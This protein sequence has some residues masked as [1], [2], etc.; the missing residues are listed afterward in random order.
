MNSPKTVISPKF[1]LDFRCIAADCEDTCC[2]GW[3][4]H[5]DK[6]HYEK[7]EKTFSNNRE[8]TD[9]FHK[10]VIKNEDW[11][12]QT[13]DFA[14]INF[15]EN[16]NCPFLDDRKLCSI[17][18]TFGESVI[19]NFCAMYPKDIRRVDD[20]LEVSAAL[21]CPEVARKVIL[22]KGSMSLNYADNSIIPRKIISKSIFSSFAKTYE[23]HIDDVR[24]I[25]FTILDNEYFP[26]HS[27]TFFTIWFAEQTVPM[28]HEGCKNIP[29]LY[30]SSLLSQFT[31]KDQLQLLHDHYSEIHI[32]DDNGL[33]LIFKILTER[34]KIA[35]FDNFRKLV[36]ESILSAHNLK[37][38][39]VDLDTLTFH[40]DK[41]VHE[42]TERKLFWE[43]NFPDKFYLFDYNF[44]KYYWYHKSYNNSPNLQIYNVRLLLLRGMIRFLFVF[45][46]ELE[47]LRKHIQSK[48]ITAQEAEPKID[49]L[50]AKVVYMVYKNNEHNS[51]ILN[52]F[53]QEILDSELT[54]LQTTLILSGF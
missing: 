12:K 8:K 14:S 50:Y 25:I 26:F 40:A 38:S 17:H 33:H 53:M 28:F 42:Y 19:P 18:A 51:S 10:Y 9:L 35:T 23:K 24:A 41:I 43:E 1:L 30:F 5:I 16:K 39:H 49:V 27:R 6:D 4:I 46:P 45:H 29:D 7:L 2:N 44:F 3:K 48:S 54:P 20:R 13:D 31:D 22:E 36:F 34:L 52:T 11:D 37:L 21:S 15:L 47:T 32:P